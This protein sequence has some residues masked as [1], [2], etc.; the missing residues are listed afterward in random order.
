[1]NF[2]NSD[3][4]AEKGL[5]IKAKP[6]TRVGSGFGKGPGLGEGPKLRESSRIRD[7]KRLIRGLF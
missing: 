2:F 6:N 3:S 1:M 5:G 4:I 7:I